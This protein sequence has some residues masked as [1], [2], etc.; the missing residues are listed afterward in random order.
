MEH[1]QFTAIV[2]NLDKIKA[3]IS[4]YCEPNNNHKIENKYIYRLE[5]QDVILYKR[6]EIERNLE[7]KEPQMM[8]QET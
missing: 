4:F 1:D 3:Y 5:S 2:P 6:I 8:K 7:K